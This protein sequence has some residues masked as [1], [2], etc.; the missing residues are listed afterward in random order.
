[1]TN[2]QGQQLDNYRLIRLLGT[3]S[4]GEV[5]LAEHVYR[6]THAPVAIKVLSELAQGDLGSF[7]AEARTA[8]LKHSNIVQILDFGVEN[9]IPF[10][11]MEYAPNGTLRERHPKRTRVSLPTIVTYVKQIA[12]ALQY[13][14]DE[15]L[16]HR[17]IKPENMLIG[18]QNQIFLS[19]FGLATI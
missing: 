7:L 2:R 10:I 9:H 16:V 11:V 13:A 14:H 19:D 12:S 18:E 8:R 5:Y 4:F 6:R 17:D 15:R 3:G 1:M